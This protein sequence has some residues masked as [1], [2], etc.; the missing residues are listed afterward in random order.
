[1]LS[2]TSGVSCV[3]TWADDEDVD[4]ELGG[5]TL[6]VDGITV[7]EVAVGMFTAGSGSSVMPVCSIRR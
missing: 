1:M 5:G 4:E 7:E 3:A 6:T 2:S